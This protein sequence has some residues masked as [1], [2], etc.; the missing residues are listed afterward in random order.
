MENNKNVNKIISTFMLVIALLLL[1]FAGYKYFTEKPEVDVPEDNT[2]EQENNENEPQETENYT[3]YDFNEVITNMEKN[4]YFQYKIVSETLPKELDIN[5][6]DENYHVVLNNNGIVTIKKGENN[7]VTLSISEVKNI[8]YCN[9]M[10]VTLYILLNNGDVYKYTLEDFDDAK[11]VPVRIDE[12]KNAEHFV[13]LEWSDCDECGGNIDLGII[14]N[15]NK[16]IV[17][18]IFST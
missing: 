7:P 11:Y 13:K 10:Y 17:L 18:E 1:C 8:D 15:N 12:I 6:A 16:Y 14:D 4:L 3:A 2:Q 5:I 9:D